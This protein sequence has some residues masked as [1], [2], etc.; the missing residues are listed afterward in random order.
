[1]SLTGSQDS[2]LDVLQDPG[3][4]RSWLY[5]MTH[6]AA[7]DRIRRNGSGERADQMSFC[8]T[9]AIIVFNPKPFPNSDARAQYMIQVQAWCFRGQNT[10]AYPRELAGTT[11]TCSR[12]QSR[13]NCKYWSSRRI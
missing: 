10:C 5:P 12:K 6:G 4:V 8:A 9:G 2:A 13:S 1:M 3:A 11:W 7:M